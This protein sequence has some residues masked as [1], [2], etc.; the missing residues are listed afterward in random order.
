M[1][2]SPNWD[3]CMQTGETTRA[4]CFSAGLVA[5]HYWRR[6]WFVKKCRPRPPKVTQGSSG[7]Q[8]RVFTFRQHAIAIR[9]FSARSQMRA[10][11]TVRNRSRA[12]SRL[13]LSTTVMSSALRTEAS[14]N[15]VSP[16]AKYTCVG[17]SR[18]M[19]VESGTTKT[20]VALGWA[21]RTSVDTMTTG[22]F[23][24]P[25]GSVGRLIYQISPRLG[26]RGNA[27]A[28]IYSLGS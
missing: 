18:T 2:F 21:L 19:L 15:P 28:V 8:N 4:T 14:D 6:L 27:A 9:T 5:R 12:G 13:S 26:V 17:T 16:G 1:S 11:L 22:R 23:P 7:R 10:L 24:F 3:T 25:A 20:V